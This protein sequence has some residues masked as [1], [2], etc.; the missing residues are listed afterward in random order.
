MTAS[1]VDAIQAAVLK[2]ARAA[3]VEYTKR[4]PNPEGK[5]VN[6]PPRGFVEKIIRSRLERSA[7]VEAFVDDAL[8]TV[9]E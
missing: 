9:I 3:I 1:K 8:A 5:A 4:N 7:L 2:A 6:K